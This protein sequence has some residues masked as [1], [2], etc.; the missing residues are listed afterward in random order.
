MNVLIF[1]GSQESSAFS[2]AGCIT[3]YLSRQLELYGIETRIFN[4]QQENIPMFDY[5]AEVPQ[6]VKHMCDLF[7][8]SAIQIWLGPLYHGGMPGLMKNC[9][10]WLELTCKNE[11]PYLTDKLI[12]L[13]CWSQGIQAMQ[14][15]NNMEAV[16]KALRAWTLPYSVPVK[17]DDIFETGTRDLKPEFSARLDQMNKLLITASGKFG[18]SVS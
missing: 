2:T 8:S 18:L 3:A 11:P 4:L 10:D 7:T 1:N 15:I 9:L 13:I 14:G 6:N 17:K 16:A 12:A 5:Y